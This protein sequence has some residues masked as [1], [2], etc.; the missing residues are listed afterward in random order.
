[1]E[2]IFETVAVVSALSTTAAIA[3][4][5]LVIALMEMEE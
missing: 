2:I 1:M 4:T 5:G 3:V